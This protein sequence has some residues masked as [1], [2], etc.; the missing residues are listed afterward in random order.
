MDVYQIV[1]DKIIG[2]LEQGTVPWKKPW[3]TSH[4]MPKNLYQ[5]E[6][7]SWDQFISSKMPAVQFTVLAYLQTSR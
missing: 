4:G 6:G 2:L 5:Q 7:V 1:T 3:A